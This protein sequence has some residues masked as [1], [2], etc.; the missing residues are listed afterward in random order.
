[1]SFFQNPAQSGFGS[2][3]LNPVGSQSEKRIMFNTEPLTNQQCTLHNA[4][5]GAPFLKKYIREI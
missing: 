1:L 5:Y 3:V 4:H 2:E